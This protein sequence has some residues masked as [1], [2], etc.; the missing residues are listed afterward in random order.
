MSNET[1]FE[2]LSSLLKAHDCDNW[3]EFKYFVDYVTDEMADVGFFD[4]DKNNGIFFITKEGVS[5]VLHF[6]FSLEEFNSE[7]EKMS[8]V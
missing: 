6:P 7:I 2:N 3:N 5:N 1:I 8:I 4:H